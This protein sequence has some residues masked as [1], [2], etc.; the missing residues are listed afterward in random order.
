VMSRG[1]V[2]RLLLPSHADREPISGFVCC[3]CY[4]KANAPTEKRG[5][6]V[7]ELYCPCEQ[8]H[9]LWGEFWWVG[10][11]YRWIFFDDRESSETYSEQVTHCPA[12]GRVLERK[13]LRA[14]SPVN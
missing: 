14:V 1:S 9:K 4:D 3:V 12:C 7:A 8:R 5:E 13:S 6:P 10:G 11:R 2:P